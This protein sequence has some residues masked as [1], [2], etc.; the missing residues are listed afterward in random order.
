M[1]L[2]SYT[3]G[4]FPAIEEG[5]KLYL[6]TELRKISNAIAELS[7]RIPNSSQTPPED[8]QVGMVVYALSPWDPG[9]GAGEYVYTP[10]GWVKLI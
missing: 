1:T 5:F 8:P 3:P 7:R 9:A 4:G 10:A 2:P 6:Q